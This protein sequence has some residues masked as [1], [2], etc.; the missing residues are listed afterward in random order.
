[1]S[2]LHI[3]KKG[4]SWKNCVGICT[5]AAPSMFGSIRGFASPVKKKNPDVFTTHCFVYRELL[6]SKTLGDEM[7]EVL[8]D[9]TKMVNFIK[10]RTVHSRM[11]KN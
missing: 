6:V 8:N 3:W 10:H 11:F 1:M 2:C 5:D 7:K 9:A 4:R